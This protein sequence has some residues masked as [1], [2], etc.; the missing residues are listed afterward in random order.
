MKYDGPGWFCMV[1]KRR[2]LNWDC[3]IEI[4]RMDAGL[5]A[6]FRSL[7]VA[8]VSCSVLCRPGHAGHQQPQ[9]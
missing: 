4:I 1:I 2:M 9:L 8:F 5:S 3:L 6:V 7:R